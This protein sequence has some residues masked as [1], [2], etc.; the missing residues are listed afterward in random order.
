MFWA[1]FEN[2]SGN[3]SE[4]KK[5]ESFQECVEYIGE[6]VKTE[7]AGK[8]TI[9]EGSADGEIVI[10]HVYDQPKTTGISGSCRK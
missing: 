7:I 5:L 1:I 10:E 3:L 4:A 2:K 6:I 9:R 8:I